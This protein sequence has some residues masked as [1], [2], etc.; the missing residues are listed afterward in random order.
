MGKPL[1]IQEDDE[2]K[3]E[4]LKAR[5]HAKTK[6]QVVRAGLMLLEEQINRKEKSDRWRKAA[7]LVSGSSK[8]V[9]FEFQKHSRLKK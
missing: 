9:N 4:E 6:I 7:A 8:E 1:M 2:K 3:I 5:L